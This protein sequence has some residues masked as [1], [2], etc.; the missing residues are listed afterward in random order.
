MESYPG[1]A[2]FMQEAFGLTVGDEAVPRHVQLS[3]QI[4]P[5][6]IQKPDEIF[7]LGVAGSL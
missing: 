1:T 5:E 6:I 7:G 4:V 3:P 2:D